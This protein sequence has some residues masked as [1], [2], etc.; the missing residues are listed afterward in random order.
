[1][2]KKKIINLPLKG[3]CHCGKIQF[4]LLCNLSDLKRC[5]CSHCRRKGFVMTT[6]KLHEFKLIS[7]KKYLKTYQWNT[8]IAKHYFCNNCGVN[9]HH[10]RRTKP[11]EYG[12]NIGCLE[13]FK[14]NWVKNVKY[15]EGVKFSIKSKIK[16]DAS[17]IEV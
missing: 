9:T 2:K 11:N 7:G 6:A 3:K 12:V 15:T 4:E 10:Q 1:M 5:N 16:N 14:M 17:L 8:K 13:D